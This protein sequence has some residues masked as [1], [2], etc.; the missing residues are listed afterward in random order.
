MNSIF[1]MESGFTRTLL[2]QL[3]QFFAF[4]LLYF[5][6]LLYW[7]PQ[8][9]KRQITPPFK[10]NV[11]GEDDVLANFDNQFTSEPVQLTPDDP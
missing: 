3:N 10:P 9:E 4:K 8:L 2:K 7:P 11:S 6:N 1:E 5:C